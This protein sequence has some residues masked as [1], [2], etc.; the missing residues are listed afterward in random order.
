M[1]WILALSMLFNAILGW[2]LYATKT[3]AFLAIVDA[4]HKIQDS[5]EEVQRS[6]GNF[7]VA[8]N[9]IK[10]FT[11]NANKTVN[12][13]DTAVQKIEQDIARIEDFLRF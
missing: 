5:H 7:N 12:K 6:I 10:G 13:I 4:A 9:K 2:T 3:D 8:V 1:K 11:D